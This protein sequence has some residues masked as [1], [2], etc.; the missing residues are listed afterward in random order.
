M[1]LEVSIGKRGNILEVG[2][3][4]AHQVCYVSCFVLSYSVSSTTSNYISKFSILIEFLVF[5]ETCQVILSSPVLNEGELDLLMKDP[6]LKAKKLSTYFDI[7]NGLDGSLEKMIKELCE[8]ADAAV[9]DGSQ[10]LVLSDRSDELVSS[11]LLILYS[12][13]YFSYYILIKI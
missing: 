7:Q 10:L 11:T 13:F 1:S 2:P 9:R 8:E 3:E 5:F 12:F 4:N 6:N